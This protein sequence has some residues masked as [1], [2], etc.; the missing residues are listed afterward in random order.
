[1]EQRLQQLLPTAT[2]G[3]ILLKRFAVHSDLRYTRVLHDKSYVLRAAEPSAV[4]CGWCQSIRVWF[5]M[6]WWTPYLS[7]ADNLVSMNENVVYFITNNCKH[8]RSVAQS[9]GFSA[10]VNFYVRDI[11]YPPLRH[12]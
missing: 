7:G 1:M 9:Q 4:V 5:T 8:H 3:K 12:H 10:T 2:A 11:F 6:L